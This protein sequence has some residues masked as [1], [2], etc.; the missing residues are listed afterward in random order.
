MIFKTTFD[1]QKVL[2]SLPE[3]GVGYQLI[4]A[5]FGNSYLIKH[6][7]VLNGTFIIEQDGK[8]IIYFNQLLKSNNEKLI[9]SSKEQELSNIE[10]ISKD[11]Y[12]NQLSEA[13]S[14]SKLSAKENPIQYANGWMP[15]IRLSAFHDDIRID[16]INKC[17]LPGSYTTTASDY[18]NCLLNKYD[19]VDRYALPNEYPVKWAF[20]IVPTTSDSFQQGIVQAAFGKNG[21]GVECY[22][23]NGTSFGTFTS[24]MPIQY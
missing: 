8:E 20:N 18:F 3:S 10:L 1:D 5:N 15:F 24:E 11:M 21:G 17:L 6:L 13:S 7:I 22:F 2:L 12:F 16:K 4:T 23:E 14:I 9:L 19:F